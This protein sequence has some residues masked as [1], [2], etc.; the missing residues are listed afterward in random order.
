MPSE[1]KYYEK[2]DIQ[3]NKMYR[4]DKF[5]EEK[6]HLNIFNIVNNFEKKNHINISEFVD[7]D[8]KLKL[9]S[10]NEI[11]EYAAK[12]ITYFRKII[13]ENKFLFCCME[14]TW[15]H[16]VILFYICKEKGLDVFCPDRCKFS[17]NKF[18]IF[19]D[20]SR[21][22]LL[23]R[24]NKKKLKYANLFKELS[25]HLPKNKNIN[26]YNDKEF[27]RLS[28]RNNLGFYK[29]RLLII[30]IFRKMNG[31]FYHY[32]HRNLSWYLFNKIECMIRKKLLTYFYRFDKVDLTKTKYVYIP[33]HV[34]PES[35]IDLVGRR[36]SNQIEFIKKCSLSLPAG[37]KIITKDHPH[38]F[39]RK[40]ANFYKQI[41]S[42]YNCKVVSTKTSVHDI[43][44]NASLVITIVG[45]ASLEALLMK[46]PSLSAVKMYYSKLCVQE[47]FE[48]ENEYLTDILNKT[49]NWK[50][51]RNSSRFK[52]D[53][54]DIYSNRYDGNV[55]PIDMN[56][57]IL[58]EDNMKKIYQVFEELCNVKN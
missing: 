6:I 18:Y 43:I 48:P 22:V 51:Y 7:T 47:T 13:N 54:C 34:Q 35:G 44:S 37:Y 40:T 52:K 5:V 14:I 23:E 4:L 2:N 19:K 3:I 12:L 36:Y 26:K 56:Q 31:G 38:D 33:L 27:I 24:K 28:Q 42:F 53:L 15:F 8:R 29:F 11:I 1:R 57:D 21:S 49:K 58:K 10:D 32:I 41:Q 30:L 17:F 9:L 39:G 50:K 55:G 45:T 20:F 25:R 16:E 46:V